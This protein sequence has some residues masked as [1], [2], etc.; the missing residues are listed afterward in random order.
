MKNKKTKQQQ[1]LIGSSTFLE[2]RS[3]VRCVNDIEQIVNTYETESEK[4]KTNG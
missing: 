3:P 1:R 2:W 4:I